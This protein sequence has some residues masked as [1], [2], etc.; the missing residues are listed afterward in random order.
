MGDVC[1]GA[2]AFS[3]AAKRMSFRIVS[4]SCADPETSDTF[5]L[6]HHSHTTCFCTQIDDTQLFYTLTHC[7]LLTF[8][9]PGSSQ[10]FSPQKGTADTVS[11]QLMVIL[12]CI[13]LIRPPIAVIDC[14]TDFLSNH[15]AQN[16]LKVHCHELFYH[17][18]I[19]KQHTEQYLPI[20]KLR[21]GLI[22]IRKDCWK[23]V[24]AT[25]LPRIPPWSMP[26]L[27]TVWHRGIFF[28]HPFNQHTLVDPDTKADM[29]G[30]AFCRT[31]YLQL[32]PLPARY[33]S[34]MHF[35]K[36]RIGQ[37]LIDANGQAHW[38]HPNSFAAAM[39]F[40]HGY[41][42]P[43]DDIAAYKLLSK[44]AFPPTAAIWIHIALHSIDKNCNT[45]FYDAFAAMLFNA[46]P[47]L[48]RSIINDEPL[49]HPQPT[50]AQSKQVKRISLVLMTSTW[51]VV[52][53]RCLRAIV[54]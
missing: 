27:P 36:P 33:R 5:S 34:N 52:S 39:G 44:S 51:T 13:K 1:A 26:T 50:A 47:P 41:H 9:L 31:I 28:E 25:K 20:N 4:A 11:H 14:T 23:G 29:A 38:I 15:A 21:C 12:E 37:W 22:L 43:T 45:T 54:G 40:R 32:A 30:D 3:E 6:N 42:L 7:H 18:I 8:H 46:I 19:D 49:L 53:S 2:G 10:F 17:H 24:G 35:S 48:F 16:S